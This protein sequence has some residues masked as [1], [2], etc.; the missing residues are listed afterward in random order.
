M[1]VS[2]PDFKRKRKIFKP[3]AGAVKKTVHAICGLLFCWQLLMCIKKFIESPVGTRCNFF[4][5]VKCT[6]VSILKHIIILGV[7]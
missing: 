5:I 1:L 7:S 4:S 3:F 2:L 6:V